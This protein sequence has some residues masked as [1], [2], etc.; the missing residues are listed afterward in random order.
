MQRPKQGKPLS[1]HIHTLY[2]RLLSQHSPYSTCASWNSRF[3]VS[4]RRSDSRPITLPAHQRRVC[5]WESPSFA[6]TTTG[7]KITQF[8]I[9]IHTTS[10]ILLPWNQS[11]CLHRYYLYLRTSSVETTSPPHPRR[12]NRLF[13]LK[14]MLLCKRK[15][16]VG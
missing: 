6:L 2:L 11:T 8:K 4:K 15:Q 5:G 1:C 16:V 3:N 12:G 7:D 9:R 13:S 14:Y 10:K